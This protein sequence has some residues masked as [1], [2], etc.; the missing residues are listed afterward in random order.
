M[1]MLIEGTVG[2]AVVVFGIDEDPGPELTFAR[3]V[4]LYAAGSDADPPDDAGPIGV[5]GQGDAGPAAL[6]FAARHPERVDR[7]A[8]IATPIPDDLELDLS[9]VTVKTLLLFGAKDLATGSTHGR[10]WQQRLPDARLE[11][12][13]QGG[14][15]LLG[16]MWKRVLSHLAPSCRR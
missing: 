13:P 12:N 8:L 15:D 1:R 5:A 10:W 7:L 9:T 6:A 11:M 2:R 4:T 3:G 16:P 14:P